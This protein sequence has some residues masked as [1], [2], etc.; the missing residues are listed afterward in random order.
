MLKVVNKKTHTHTHKI[1][2]NFQDWGEA[3]YKSTGLTNP[4]L[5]LSLL[6]KYML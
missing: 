4:I 1:Y 5:I 3:P 6:F 2:M